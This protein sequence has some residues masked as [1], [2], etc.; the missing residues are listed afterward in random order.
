MIKKITVAKVNKLD[1]EDRY[2][3]HIDLKPI[4]YSHNRNDA[5]QIAENLNRSIEPF[6]NDARLEGIK[7]GI[8]E[9]EYMLTKSGVHYQAAKLLREIKPE[10]IFAA[11]EA[12]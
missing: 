6:I 3:V 1:G 2:M 8:D 10:Q 7:I 9:C 12:K 11:W 4:T 5:E